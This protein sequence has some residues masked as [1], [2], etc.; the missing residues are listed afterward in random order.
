M[1]NAQLFFL[2]RIS[3]SILPTKNNML[4]SFLSTPATRRFFSPIQKILRHKSATST[5]PSFHSIHPQLPLTRNAQP[6]YQSP[7]QSSHQ[8]FHST[9]YTLQKNED[10]ETNTDPIDPTIGQR[11][12][13]KLPIRVQ[14]LWKKYGMIFLGNYLT[15]YVGSIGIFFVLYDNGILLPS[16]MGASVDMVHDIPSVD[17]DLDVEILGK[18]APKLEH[19]ENQTTEQNNADVFSF[20][21]KRFHLEAYAP[22][23]IKPWMGNFAIAWLTSK[24]V[25]PVRMLLAVTTTPYLAKFIRR[26]DSTDN[27]DITDNTDNTDTRNKKMEQ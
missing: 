2:H 19:S 10:I 17:N 27:T 13:S 18:D 23:E 3:D 5:I 8:F 25:E 1:F 14:E 11:I 22:T 6:I 24:L 26:G 15:I 21:L 16:D 12:L 20:I 9:S 4:K 7:F